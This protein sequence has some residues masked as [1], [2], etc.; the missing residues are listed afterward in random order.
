MTVTTDPAQLRPLPLFAGLSD[1][2]LDRVNRVLHASHFAAGAMVLTA[3]HLGA[4]I[5]VVRTG[6]LK[7]HVVHPDG[8]EVT[9][10]LLGAGELIGELAVLDHGGRSADV[11]V[12]EAADL[13]WFSRA[14]FHA[15]RRDLPRMEDNLLE[16]LVRRLRFA[17]AHIEALSTLDVIGR[18]AWQVLAL[19]DTYGQPA[20]GGGV[21]IPLRL[22][23][24]EL[25]GLVGATRNRVN[26]SLVEFKRQ[27]ILTEDVGHRIRLLD[28][29]ALD[30]YCR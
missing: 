17:N 15:L 26:Q 25:A 13:L 8:R 30:A 9:L 3:T 22:T 27:G 29:V 23:Q 14:N 12:L 28:P 10:A 18:V 21:L 5:Y 7:A 1:A 19:A 6:T 2:E 4:A 11:V 24:A 16:I 20:P